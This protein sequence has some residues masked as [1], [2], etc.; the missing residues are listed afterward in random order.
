MAAALTSGP[1]RPTPMGLERGQA[2]P[3]VALGL[4]RR[5]A[6]RVLILS[7]PGPLRA[8]LFRRSSPT[9]PLHCVHHCGKSQ[10]TFTAL[11][12]RE[13]TS[14]SSGVRNPKWFCRATRSHSE[15]DFLR[16]LGGP[17]PWPFRL[18]GHLPPGSRPLPLCSTP[19][20]SASTTTGPALPSRNGPAPQGPPTAPA[21]GA[22][23]RP[24]PQRWEMRVQGSLTDWV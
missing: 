15:A 24:A 10:H 6:P 3:G 2:P 5:V 21:P 12:Q 11:K 18:L 23:H 20:S 16:R 22:Q 13:C 17:V 1:G 4:E 7:P 19:S 9:S 14:Y 8:L